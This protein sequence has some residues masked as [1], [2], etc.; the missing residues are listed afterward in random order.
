MTLPPKYSDTE[1]QY[2]LELDTQQPDN[3]NEKSFIQDLQDNRQIKWRVNHFLFKKNLLPLLLD[4]STFRKWKFFKSLNWLIALFIIGFAI[5]T[6]DYKIL[7]FLIVFPFLIITFDHWI[8]ILNMTIIIG[9]KTL[10][11]LNIP[12]FWFFVTAIVVGYLLNRA[13]DEMIERKILR[14]ALNDWTT[15]WRYYSNKLIW[16]D[17]TALNNEHQLLIDKYPELRSL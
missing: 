11:K 7:F 6:G 17:Q 1:L 4:N 8:F 10:A 3:L 13:I 9:I 16:I 15:F 12:Y 2:I 14:Q 5:W